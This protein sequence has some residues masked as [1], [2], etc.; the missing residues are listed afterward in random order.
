[1]PADRERK[2]LRQMNGRRGF[3]RATLEIGD[4]DDLKMFAIC[5]IAARQVALCLYDVSLRVR[6]FGQMNAK[7]VDVGQRIE[8]PPAR[9]G[10]RLRAFAGERK[11]P[12][13]AVGHAD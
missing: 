8:P 4:G 2:V 11:L 5:S 3:A 10:L 12:E 9:T 1:M 7:R 13:I 6:L